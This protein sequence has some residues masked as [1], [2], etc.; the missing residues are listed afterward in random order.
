[1]KTYVTDYMKESL[2]NHVLQPAEGNNVAAL[3]HRIVK[4]GSMYY[5]AYI[6]EVATSLCITGDICLGANNH[7]IVSAPGYK[8]DWFAGQL[9][10]GY[11]CEKFLRH[12]WQWAVAIEGIQWQIR[13]AIKEEE[14][15]V[16]LESWWL[17][18]ADKLQKFL[19]SPGWKY[20]TPN[21]T[22][23]YEFMSDEL[24]DD[25]T[26]LPGYD[27]PRVQAGWLCAIQQRYSELSKETKN[28]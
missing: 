2:A 12:E 9:S 6:S 22:E 4:P 27:Y 20:D 23:F 26:D 14:V 15:T 18:N 13:E 24:G 21:M 10:E 16:G 8:M 7:G 5:S 17:D 25:G 3:A 11:L 19:E 1:M 28:G